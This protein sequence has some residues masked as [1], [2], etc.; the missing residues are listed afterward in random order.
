[1]ETAKKTV[2]QAPNNFILFS[3]SE[4]GAG[5]SAFLDKEN[6]RGMYSPANRD[7][8]YS[9]SGFCPSCASHLHSVIAMSV[10]VALKEESSGLQA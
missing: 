7:V 2:L 5:T 8:R 10:K 6:E 9:S 4:M 1:M 3:S